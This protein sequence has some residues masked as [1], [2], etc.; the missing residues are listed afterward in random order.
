MEKISGILPASARVKSV[1]LKNSQPVRPGVPT[2]GRPEGWT[3]ADRVSLSAVAR[4]RASQ[5]IADFKS[6]DINTK[7]RQMASDA[8]DQFFI[9]RLAPKAS[10][11]S[12][13]MIESATELAPK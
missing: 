10:D 8:T 4:E 13:E 5:E 6:S 1:D 11:E 7:K 12:V 3:A 2:F 9:N